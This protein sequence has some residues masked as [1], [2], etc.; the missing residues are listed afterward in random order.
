MSARSL[1]PLAPRRALGGLLSATVL[2]AAVAAGIPGLAAELRA[3]FAFEPGTWSV[4]AGEALAIWL[5]NLRVLGV[6][7]FAAL[8]AREPHFVPGLDAVVALV[9]GA[10]AALVGLALGAY[11][12]A[13][14]PWLIHLPLEWAGLAVGLAAYLSSRHH[15][16][17]LRRLAHAALAGTA[18]L[19]LAAAVETWATPL[20]LP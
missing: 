7:L 20:P 9:L 17:C 13:L 8:A 18:L 14:L 3:W 11:G 2:A 1:A 19:A 15:T 4:G 12:L 16:L 10:N 6:L 5:T